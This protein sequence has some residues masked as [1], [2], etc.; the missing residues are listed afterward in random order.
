M[1][2]VVPAAAAPGGPAAAAPQLNPFGGNYGSQQPV[3]YTSLSAAA[4]NG[5]GAHA[6]VLQP[7]AAP[8]AAAPAAAAVGQKRSHNLL[9]GALPAG[10]GSEAMRA[11]LSN[12]MQE[13]DTLA[14]KDAGLSRSLAPPAASATSLEQLTSA[15]RE[16]ANHIHTLTETAAKREAAIGQ[17]QAR[18]RPP[19]APRPAAPPRARSP[20]P[21][22]SRAQVQLAQAQVVARQIQEGA[23]AERQRLTQQ[24]HA[25]M[26]QAQQQLEESLAG[27]ARQNTSLQ[28]LLHR[29]V[30]IIVNTN[31]WLHR[32]AQRCASQS[33]RRAP[34]LK[35]WESEGTPPAP[36]A[37]HPAPPS[38]RSTCRPSASTRWPSSTPPPPPPSSL[39][40]T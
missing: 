15:N 5:G 32:L 36:P 27:A 11:R 18:R 16:Q 17:M 12:L 31:G 7:T 24:H 30:T 9:E 8:P 21:A 34:M 13:V 28:E 38:C 20:P 39:A 10:I 35:P 4:A 6:V 19:P 3:G 22:A 37:H 26:M 40:K 14:K 29:L 2:P 1:A 33:V 25:T 23:Q